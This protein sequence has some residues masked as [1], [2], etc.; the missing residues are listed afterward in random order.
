MLGTVKCQSKHC[1]KE[2]KAID[3]INYKGVNLCSP[4]CSHIFQIE[5]YLT[6]VQTK[7]L[8]SD[9]LMEEVQSHFYCLHK[10]IGDHNINK[11]EIS[12]NIE[13]PLTQAVAVS[14]PA[15]VVE[16]AKVIKKSDPIEYIVPI[17]TENVWSVTGK[18]VEA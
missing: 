18:H 3:G 17:R 6:A 15:V 14:N 13:V 2:Y 9:D 12:S 16:E 8:N 10:E 1:N 7:G 5:Q 4:V 11:G